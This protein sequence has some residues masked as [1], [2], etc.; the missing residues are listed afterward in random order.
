MPELASVPG[1]LLAV[2]AESSREVTKKKRRVDI[3]GSGRLSSN[4]SFI[5]SGLLDR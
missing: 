2:I 3:G 5:C 1:I 4:A